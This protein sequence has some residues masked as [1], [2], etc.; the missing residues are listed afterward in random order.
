MSGIIRPEDRVYVAKGWGYEDWLYN[1]IYCGKILFI[2]RGK[3]CSWHYHD[4]KDEVIHCQSGAIEMLFGDDDDIEKAQKAGKSPPSS[5]VKR[6]KMRMIRK[7]EREKDLRSQ[8][9]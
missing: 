6:K 9:Y 1:G 4:I 3:K 8:G 7:D 5:N 2:K